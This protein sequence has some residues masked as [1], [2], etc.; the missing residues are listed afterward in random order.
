[1]VGQERLHGDVRRP[2]LHPLRRQRPRQ[3]RPLLLFL[4]VIDEL[5]AI[6]Y[7]SYAQ[8]CL[9]I[10]FIESCQVYWTLHVYVPSY[11]AQN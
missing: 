7:A 2:A 4:A 6:G 1:M 5:L 8:I 3:V 9:C 11:V 10:S